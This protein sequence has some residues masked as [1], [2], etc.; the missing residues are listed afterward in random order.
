MAR[1]FAP[2]R[3]VHPPSWGCIAQKIRKQPRSSPCSP[4]VSTRNPTHAKYTLSRCLA[5]TLRRVLCR[6]QVSR[7]FKRLERF[8]EVAPSLGTFRGSAL[9]PAQSRPAGGGSR[10]SAEG[11]SRG[12]Y[13]RIAGPRAQALVRA[14]GS[15]S[16]VTGAKG[17][18][19][20]GRGGGGAFC[21][22]WAIGGS[23]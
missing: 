3:A 7:V 9:A 18:R 19:G 12:G 11:V 21:A 22:L 17:Y 15:L 20:G 1:F 2:L 16:R 13:V 8:G 5:G 23:A 4:R 14:V 10:R 6:S